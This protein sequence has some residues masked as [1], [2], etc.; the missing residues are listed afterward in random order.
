[1][2][3]H[4]PGQRKAQVGSRKATG[5]KS[6]G[7][8]GLKLTRRINRTTMPIPTLRATLNSSNSSTGMVSHEFTLA[9]L[10]TK[11]PVSNGKITGKQDEHIP[12]AAKAEIR[13]PKPERAAY[14]QP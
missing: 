4:D 11:L 12:T 2:A 5:E 9:N 3:S 10:R 6:R 13:R 7:A 14:P 1:M 8:A